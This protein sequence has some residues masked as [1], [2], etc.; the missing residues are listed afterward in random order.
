LHE[1]ITIQLRPEVL[2]FDEVIL[3]LKVMGLLYDEIIIKQRIIVW[4]CE[5]IHYE[6]QILLHGMLLL[7]LIKLVLMQ[8]I[9]Y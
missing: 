8:V 2:L 7:K 6:I 1:V 3:H 4:L 9:E 5:L